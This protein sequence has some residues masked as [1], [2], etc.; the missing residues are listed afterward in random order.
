LDGE[1][2][3]CAVRTSNPGHAL[4]C[5][6]VSPERAFSVVETLMNRYSFSGWGI[7]TMAAGESRYNPI[8]YH[9]GTIW[10]H[11]NALI[12]LGFARYGYRREALRIF[13]GMFDAMQHMDLFRPPE[14][15]CGFSR[16]QGSA[17]TQYPVACAPQA[18][19]SAMPFAV[20]EACL[21]LSFD[22][23]KREIRLDRAQL[24]GR[25]DSLEIAGLELAGGRV[26]LVLRRY[27]GSVGVEV[28]K[29]EGDVSIV[30]AK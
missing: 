30:A 23:E 2:Q 1:K 8:S 6:I 12:A 24:P 14:L 21:G 13:T 22:P 10:P 15:F 11:D 27:P 25:I 3:Q 7:R 16:R 9:N 26:E 19:A 28:R 29:R 4:Y 17:P 20:L 5:G 18:W